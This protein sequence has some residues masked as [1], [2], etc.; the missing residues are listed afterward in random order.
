MSIEFVMDSLD[1]LLITLEKKDN[2]KSKIL[3]FMVLITPQFSHLHFKTFFIIG[4]YFARMIVF[5]QIADSYTEEFD[6]NYMGFQRDF[7]K[8]IKLWLSGAPLDLI[9]RVILRFR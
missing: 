3:V 5:F 1:T 2:P 6:T 8:P 7:K 9:F 4:R